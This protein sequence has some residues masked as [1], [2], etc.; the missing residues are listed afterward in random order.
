M[1]TSTTQIPL[2]TPLNKSNNLSQ[3][4]SGVWA[5][6]EG[7]GLKSMDGYSNNFGTL[8]NGAIYQKYTKGSCVFFDGTDDTVNNIGQLSTY[9]FIMNTQ[10]FTV[11]M[12][13]Q[14]NSN[15]A[16]QTLFATVNSIVGNKGFVLLYENG[17]GAG[18]KAFRYV[19]GNGGVVQIVVVTPD[20]IIT[21][22]NWHN[23]VI[24]GNGSG[25]T[26]SFYIDSILTT[27]TYTT[28][29]T[30]FTAG[31]VTNKLQ[32]G[33]APPSAIPFN[34]RMNNIMI[35]NRTLSATEVR[36]LYIN[37]YQMYQGYGGL[38]K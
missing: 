19:E 22:A 3:R 26:I 18:T 37:P 1:R 29:F 31:D 25:N 27:S 20:N 4:V 28:S 11:S 8:A 34:G 5:M 17:A 2:G 38:K 14:F 35:Y 12:W 36:Q 9:S 30:G 6:N 10:V 24:T 32:F 15:T 16:R 21:D 13:I 7:G 33:A 23:V